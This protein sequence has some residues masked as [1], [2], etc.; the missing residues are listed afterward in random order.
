MFG[1]VPLAGVLLF[2]AFTYII[3]PLF[4]WGRNRRRYEHREVSSQE[5]VHTAFD[6]EDEKEEK[7]SVDIS[8]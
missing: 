8:T 7:T 2:L 5:A 3:K 1:I 6:D 4:I